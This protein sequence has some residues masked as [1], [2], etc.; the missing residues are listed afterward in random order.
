MKAAVLQ[1]KVAL[2][3]PE[4]NIAALQRLMPR[5]M[6]GQPDVVLLPE[7]WRT[8]FYP[9]PIADFADTEGQESCALLAGLARKYA[10]N[11]VGGTVASAR[12]GRIYNTCYVF[13]RTGALVTSYDKTHLFSPSGEHE[14]F[15][16]GDRFVTFTLDGV[17]CGILTCYDIRF[18]E[19][20]RKLALAGIQ[21]LFIPAA[22]PMKRLLHWQTLIRARAIENQLFVVACNA[23]GHSAIIDPW[24]EILTEAEKDETILQGTLNLPMLAEVRS[25]INVYNDQRPEL[26]R[27]P[28]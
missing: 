10:V 19:A 8:G 6:E 26:Y 14:D 22:W 20:A 17:K 24:G 25:T 3:Q 15:T 18:P 28:L 4:E 11:I 5:A 13:D 2:G 21:M 23:L 1:M 9:K 16:A 7:L 12:E 27:Q